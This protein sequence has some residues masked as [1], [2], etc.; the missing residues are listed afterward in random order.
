MSL[1]GL[2]KA[3]NKTPVKGKMC[4]TKIK[5]VTIFFRD[6]SGEGIY[7]GNGKAL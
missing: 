5:R 7:E 2:K 3:I 4:R 1:T 6:K